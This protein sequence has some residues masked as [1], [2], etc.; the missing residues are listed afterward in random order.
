MPTELNPLD[1]KYYCGFRWLSW[2]VK[3]MNIVNQIDLIS[4]VFRIIANFSNKS[5]A[6]LSGCNTL[7]LKQIT[8]S[9]RTMAN[10][11]NLN[12]FKTTEVE[13]DKNLISFILRTKQMVFW[14]ALPKI[15]AKE[16]TMGLMSD[17]LK[18]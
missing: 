1:E 5:K 8:G 4:L 12:N 17:L 3:L 13:V 9:K 7:V 18:I 16:A 2:L 15:I 11:I 14:W 10:W 6:V